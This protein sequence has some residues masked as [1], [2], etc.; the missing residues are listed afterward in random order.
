M[1]NKPSAELVAIVVSFVALSSLLLGMGLA[2]GLAAE[3]Q[4]RDFMARNAAWRAEAAADRRAFQLAM[5]AWRQDLRRLDR[6]GSRPE[7]TR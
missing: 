3:A 6:R 7:A 4:H 1:M 5:E 2:V